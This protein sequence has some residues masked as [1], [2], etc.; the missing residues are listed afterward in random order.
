VQADP[1]LGGVGGEVGNGIAKLQCNNILQFNQ[2][3]PVNPVLPSNRAYSATLRKPL[4][5]MRDEFS[6]SFR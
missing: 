1:A 2:L 5:L 4:P 6:M 3:G